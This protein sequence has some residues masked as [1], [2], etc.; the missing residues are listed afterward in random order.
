[1]RAQAG[2]DAYVPMIVQT[3]ERFPTLTAARLYVMGAMARARYAGSAGHFRHRVALL[4]PRRP[5][6][7]YLRLRTL[8]ASRHRSTGGTS[9]TW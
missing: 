2:V 8:P 4:R 3:L 9:A 5:A 1:M 7:A 6:E